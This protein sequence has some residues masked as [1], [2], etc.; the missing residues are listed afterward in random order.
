VWVAA[1]AAAGTS[2]PNNWGHGGRP[3][4]IEDVTEEVG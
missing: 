2:I 1:L 4:V 3:E